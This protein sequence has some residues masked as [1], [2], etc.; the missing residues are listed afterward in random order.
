MTLPRAWIA[1]TLL[2]DEQEMIQ[3]LCETLEK[4]GSFGPNPYYLNYKVNT[5][6]SKESD[7]DGSL[8]VP[9]LFIDGRYGAV[10]KTS[11]SRLSEL[12]RISC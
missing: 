6:Y 3:K 10:C 1:Y 2:K 8:D 11:L 4:N 7:N 9:V 5:G 12:M